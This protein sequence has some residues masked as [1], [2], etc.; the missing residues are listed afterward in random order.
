MVQE[1]FPSVGFTKQLD[2]IPP[3][4]NVE[5]IY[6]QK[7]ESPAIIAHQKGLLLIFGKRSLIPPKVTPDTIGGRRKAIGK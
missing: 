1:K 5:N 6:V 3:L 4:C 2:Y 7:G